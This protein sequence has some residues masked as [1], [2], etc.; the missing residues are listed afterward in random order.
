MAKI[1]AFGEIL[2]RLAPE[3][4]LRF[5]QADRLRVTHGGKEADVAVSLANYGHA[6]SFV[7]KL[8]KNEVAQMAINSLRR[9]GVDTVHV[10][11]GGDRTGVCFHEKGV[12]QRPAK[13]VCDRAG[14]AFSGA[15]AKDF[16]WE[17]ILDGMRWFH[18]S[19]IT[20]A[21]GPALAEI[22][23]EACK[24]AKAKGVVVSCE[25][26]HRKSL[27]TPEQANE[28]MSRLCE[29]ADIGIVS[30]EDARDV[31]GIAPASAGDAGGENAQ[32]AC[33]EAAK[34]LA[35]R[36]KFSKTAITLRARSAGDGRW[37]AVLY[38]SG[39]FH[40]SRSYPMCVVDPAGGGASFTAALIHSVLGGT[41]PQ[42]TVDFAAAAACLKFGVEGGSNHASVEEVRALM[43][44]APGGV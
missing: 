11:R 39:K 17:K 2:L 25:V 42:T 31:F 43:K 16:K 23:E 19:G 44:T 29:Y 40:V 28:T 35:E 3:G 27:W 36:F 14:S 37:S 8:P 13:T 12:S 34:Q 20:P 32:E 30:G 7:S 22:C 4:M 18:F 9:Y 24:T 10:A 21:L 15:V 41:A 5:V 6:V 33:K 38:D 1:V 26:N